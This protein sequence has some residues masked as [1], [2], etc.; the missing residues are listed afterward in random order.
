V[1]HFSR[2]SAETYVECGG[3]VLNPVHFCMSA[4]A[5]E[6]LRRAGAS[7]IEIAARPDEASLLALVTPKS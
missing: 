3:D 5:A 4:R 6:P 1:L 7:R 2:R